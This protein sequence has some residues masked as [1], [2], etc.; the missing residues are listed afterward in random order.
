MKQNMEKTYGLVYSQ[1][2]LH[3]LIQKG[4][5]R[6]K[7]YD[8]VQQIANEAWEKETSFFDLLLASNVMEYVQ[9]SEIKACFD[10]SFHVKE[11]DMIFSRLELN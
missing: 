11:V 2:V 4:I 8:L 7:A 5:P 3:L 9:A 1:Q 6:E 10:P